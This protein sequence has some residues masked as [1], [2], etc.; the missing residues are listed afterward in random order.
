MFKRSLV[1][2]AATAATAIVLSA[3]SSNSETSGPTG[4]VSATVSGNAAA[5]ALVPAKIKTA[6]KLIVG[7]N[8]PYSPNEYLDSSGKVV[9]FDV[10]LLDATAKV[11]GLTTDYEQA[12]F[13]KI[14]PAIT[15]GT[16]DVGM[17]SFTD[18]KEREATV[19]FTT[20]FSAGISW[21]SQAG[22]TVDPEQCLRID[23]VGP[24]DHDRR[25]R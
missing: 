22:K 20:Y 13:D 23:R 18:T 19:D 4:S 25:H 24:D 10:D 16:Y 11:L 1:L 15:A 3:C 14:I 9:G 6:G 17:S 5:A 7:V 2:V 12:D 21:A 8:P